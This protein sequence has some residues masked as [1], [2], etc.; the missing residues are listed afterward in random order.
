MYRVVG[1]YTVRGADHEGY[2]REKHNFWFKDDWFKLK[3]SQTLFFIESE[4]VG[5]LK[6]TTQVLK[7]L[8][9]NILIKI[10]AQQNPA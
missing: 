8:M 5:N 3:F 1:L 10:L 7:I 4:L 9:Q 2:L 6:I